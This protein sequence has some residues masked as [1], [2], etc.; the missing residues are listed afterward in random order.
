MSPGFFLVLEGPEGA[1]KSTLAGAILQELRDRGVDPLSVRE[2]GGTPAAEHARRALLE[3][4]PR[5]DPRTELL[6]VAAARA[7]LVQSVIRPAL[8]AGRFVLS[9]RFELSTMAYQGAGRGIA[10]ETVALVNR[11]ATGGLQ[12]DLTLILDIPPD[13]GRSRQDAAGK[14][15]DRLEQEDGAFHARVADAYRSAAGTGFVHIDGT[16]PPAEVLV[17]ARRAIDRARPG[18]FAVAAG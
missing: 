8:E 14:S 12:P 3:P 18:T 17:E 11:I 4:G 16:L 7:H 9:D 15:R 1:G 5:L 13:V 6:F 10:A 2:P